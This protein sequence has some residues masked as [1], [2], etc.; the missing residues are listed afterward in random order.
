MKISDLDVHRAAHRWI[1]HHRAHGC[2]RAARWSMRVIVAIG[3]QPARHWR[4][5]APRT[6]RGDPH[7]RCL[8]GG[9]RRETPGAGARLPAPSR[10]ARTCSA[11]TRSRG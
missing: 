8:S 5:G 10:P 6:G 1:A 11:E 7:C 2:R 3:T 4:A 9:G